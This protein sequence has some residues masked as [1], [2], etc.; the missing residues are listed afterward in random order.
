MCV[1]CPNGTLGTGGLCR[2]TC[3]A[4]GC[5]ENGTIRTV[6]VPVG[7]DTY[8][9]STIDEL[10]VLSSGWVT[11][12]AGARVSLTDGNYTGTGCNDTSCDVQAPETFPIAP[13]LVYTITG[14][15]FV[16]IQREG[17][18]GTVITVENSTL[19]HSAECDVVLDV[20]VARVELH[21]T[22][23][24]TESVSTTYTDEVLSI[25]NTGGQPSTVFSVG[26]DASWISVERITDINCV[27]ACAP[28][29]LP[30]VLEPGQQLEVLLRS[31]GSS[32]DVGAHLANGTVITSAG[33]LQFDVHFNVL[34]ADLRVMALPDRL[35]PVIV[36]A[37]RS[38]SASFTLYNSDVEAVYWEL[39]ECT[40][41]DALTET[42]QT[43]SFSDC[44][45]SATG[46]LEVNGQSQVELFY[47]APRFV[48]EYST[49]TT[50]LGTLVS[51][52]GDP[53]SW[54]LESTVIVIPDVIVPSS[55]VVSPLP[56]IVA[57]ST[58]Q[59]TV[60]PKDLYGNDIDTFGLEFDA[61]AR[62]PFNTTETVED[63]PF[64]SSFDPASGTYSFAVLLMS[65]GPYSFTV[66][67]DGELVPP[68]KYPEVLALVCDTA[69][70][71]PNEEGN[72]CICLDGF[73]RQPNADILEGVCDRCPAGYEPKGTHWVT[74]PACTGVDDGTGTGLATCT[75][76]DD[77]TNLDC[78]QW[79]PGVGPVEDPMSMGTGGAYGSAMCG[80]EC[81]LAED[82]SSC[83]VVASCSATYAGWCIVITDQARCNSED[84]VD[85]NENPAG[86]G[87]CQFSSGACI[88]RSAADC[89]A[90][91]SGSPSLEMRT[92][93]ESAGDCA[94]DGQGGDCFYTPSNVTAC[95][96]AAD[97]QSC[98]VDG[99]D[100][101]YHPDNR[102]ETGV[103]TTYTPRECTT[104]LEYVPAAYLEV[105]D[106]YNAI[107]DVTC[108]PGWTNVFSAN[109]GPNGGWRPTG[110]ALREEGCDPC[111]GMPGT[112]SPDGM[113]CE[114]CPIG[115]KPDGTQ[116]ICVSCP[117]GEYYNRL[118]KNPVCQACPAGQELVTSFLP[119]EVYPCRACPEGRAGNDGTCQQCP[120]GE[121]PTTNADGVPSAECKPCDVGWAGKLGKCYPC[122]PGTHSRL[123]QSSCLD[124]PFNQYRYK[125]ERPTCIECD[126][127]MTT[128]AMRSV[129]ITQCQC[130]DGTYDILDAAMIRNSGALLDEK[131]DHVPDCKLKWWGTDHWVDDGRNTEH[132]GSMFFDN[133]ADDDGKFALLAPDKHRTCEAFR[134]NGSFCV[135]IDTCPEGKEWRPPPVYQQPA[136][137]RGLL[138]VISDL[139]SIVPDLEA[140][141][142]ITWAE[143]ME[144]KNLQHGSWKTA[145]SDG[146]QVAVRGNPIWCF[147]DGWIK[148]PG[149]VEVNGVYIN[150]NV[151]QAVRTY[152]STGKRCVP[153]S[154]CLECDFD[155]YQGIP[156]VAEGWTTVNTVIEDDYTKDSAYA[157]CGGPNCGIDETGAWNCS[158]T[159]Q[160][161]ADAGF[162]EVEGCRYGD[163]VESV[164]SQNWADKK[165]HPPEGQGGASAQ[166]EV[167]GYS[168]KGG[169]YKLPVGQSALVAE[170]YGFLE[171]NVLG[172]PIRINEEPPYGGACRA[173]LDYRFPDVATRPLRVENAAQCALETNLLEGPLEDGEATVG[174]GFRSLP[175]TCKNNVTDR[176]ERCNSGYAGKLW[177]ASH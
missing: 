74:D 159:N 70:S 165:N 120:D 24:D 91:P 146:T 58:A 67:Y 66:T 82:A 13:Q 109:V 73:A 33:A 36:R 4:L 46:H 92:A 71:E 98:A 110:N 69:V 176:V 3:E 134:V 145:G 127:G 2:S 156:F 167:A 60:E 34:A 157:G 136:Q 106:I 117:E 11:S 108:K 164:A 37:G 40:V 90:I 168:G 122:P 48:G 100:C 9:F 62:G 171:R 18:N 76:T 97:G 132:G 121:E 31:A 32:I 14:Y 130:G 22:V 163:A 104:D 65:T 53:T 101:V 41:G 81:R 140:E 43:F 79:Q 28:L 114:L 63:Y 30:Q 113:G 87:R 83:A 95:A 80:T 116:T 160:E 85:E 119:D 68:V 126:G 8:H 123:D 25:A 17:P 86:N 88:A 103:G 6:D 151:M 128:A 16:E 19:Q 47:R 27:D 148:Q 38:T 12:G 147:P 52:T 137:L 42:N 99:G 105:G 29:E 94:Y 133:T 155:G 173:E 144:G 161:L 152:E 84:A 64:R 96:L 162:D 72:E 125:E 107:S 10:C 166:N 158:L 142:E 118:L 112:V 78:S 21:P 61:I 138:S 55:S 23:I 169:F 135:D 149:N 170:P 89:E 26:L 35:P 77:H 49:L 75:G 172:C 131:G 20:L 129:N 111:V 45:G 175:G 5:P 174:T 93:C 1:N 153:C 139:T 59:V 7:A 15:Q 150:K 124:C 141:G 51:G 39:L 50:V 57:R 56:D 54:S 177:C 102:G 143:R 44:G 115:Q 154:D